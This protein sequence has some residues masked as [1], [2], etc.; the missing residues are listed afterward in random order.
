[1]KEPASRRDGG[2]TRAQGKLVDQAQQFLG[3]VYGAATDLEGLGHL[4]FGVALFVQVQEFFIEAAEPRLDRLVV[5][6]ATDGIRER[7]FL[8]RGHFWS[9]LS[10][11]IWQPSL[12]GIPQFYSPAS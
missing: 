7:L 12:R 8:A 1:M 2:S 10:L 11:V 6:P 5:V 3:A 4:A 9:K